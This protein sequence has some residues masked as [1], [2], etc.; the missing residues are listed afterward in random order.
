LDMRFHLSYT[1]LDLS[2]AMKIAGL[3]SG[4]KMIPLLNCGTGAICWS[5]ASVFICLY[6]KKE[7]G[8]APYSD[9]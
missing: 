1:A 2:P 5:Y 6:P 3:R 7:K 8:Q 4:I 9:A